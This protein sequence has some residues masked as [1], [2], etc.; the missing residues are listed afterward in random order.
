[1]CGI[2][3]FLNK[4][5]KG[6]ADECRDILGAMVGALRHRG[7]DGEGLWVD[8]SARAGLG[9][10]RLAILDLS[11]A[12]AQPM[13]SSCGRYVITFNGEIYNFREM[14]KKLEA[15]GRSFRGASDTETL[16]E[17]IAQ[18]GIG[19]A[20]GQ[21]NGMF[22][23]ALWDKKERTL[24]LARDRIGQK[25]LYYGWLGKTLVFASELKAIQKHPLFK[26]NIN[27]SIINSFIHYGYIPEPYSIW[28]G[29]YKLP[30]GTMAVIPFDDDKEEVTPQRYWSV[31]TD[32]TA[33]EKISEGGAKDKLKELLQRS[34][35]ES[36][37][38][39]VPLG[40]FLSGGI[41]SSLI[42]AL[43]Q[44]Q[45]AEKVHSFSIGFDD[46]NYNEAHHAKAVAA[47]LGTEHTEFYVQPNDILDVIPNLSDI[48][49]EPFAD[50][51]QIPTYLMCKMAR[52]DVTV[53]LSG[54]G[55]DELFGGYSR[56][57]WAEHIGCLIK[58]TPYHLRAALCGMLE[59]LPSSWSRGKLQRLA[60]ILKN[61][62]PQQAYESLLSSWPFETPL[63]SEKHT[64]Y[65]SAEWPQ[66]EDFRKQMQI[67]DMDVYLPGDILT[68]IDRASMAHS[69]EVR[70]PLLDHRIIEFVMG[71]P[72]GIRNKPQKGLL[73]Q[74]LYDYVPR[75]LIDRPK[76]GFDMP[77]D[78]WLRK[79][80][81]DWAGD[82]LDLK[83]L[84]DN[85]F[86][87]TATIQ[88][89]WQKHLSG[90]SDFHYPLW[91]ILVLQSWL[92][93]QKAAR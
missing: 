84:E 48:Y 33:Q 60:Y 70:V 19:K 76:K 30:A 45:S 59:G 39:D 37:V 89:T 4:G 55:G 24:T 86:A 28:Q 1:M 47:H 49:D 91:N 15:G 34:V 17:A 52:K 80:L 85:G 22:A 44:E 31:G 36:M 16:L 9:H 92:E 46:A 54:D 35:S 14:R 20:L 56:Y 13:E 53:C 18:E 2:V 67:F 41:D 8:E 90:K 23:F 64:N 88:N 40:G 29:V 75:D 66:A 57:D 83:K 38:S 25:P 87:N 6:S 81:R 3:G 27:D 10:T 79:D 69:L 73:R 50:I 65:L 42:I 82:L 77:L 61:K 43:M 21:A 68:K 11:E 62:T 74:V 12:G 71:L 72:A 26:A 51:S 32:L 58:Y 93:S 63:W 78:S 5:A 7:P